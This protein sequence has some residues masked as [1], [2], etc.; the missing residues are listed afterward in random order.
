MAKSI[1]VWVFGL[2]AAAIFGGMVGAQLVPGDGP[3]LGV[4][5]GTFASTCARLWATGPS[6]NAN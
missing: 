1:A 6:Q 5:G 2:L 4:L 3:F